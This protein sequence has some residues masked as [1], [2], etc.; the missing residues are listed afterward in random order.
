TTSTTRPPVSTST[1]RPAATTT[2]SPATTTP[3]PTVTIIPPVT[4]R[5]VTPTTGAPTTAAPTTPTTG[6]PPTTPTTRPPTTTTTTPDPTKLSTKERARFEAAQI[7]GA[8]RSRLSHLDIRSVV[9]VGTYPIE[10]HGDVDV[11]RVVYSK[12]TVSGGIAY[13]KA[14]E[15]PPA[16]S[17]PCLNPAFA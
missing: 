14:F 11:V 15:A 17:V 2:R 1:T 10:G 7:L 16:E 12:D 13:T 5:P 3:P 9:L 8:V 4:T 6:A